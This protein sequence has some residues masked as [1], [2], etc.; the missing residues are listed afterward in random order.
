MHPAQ[1]AVLLAAHSWNHEPFRRLI[2][3]VDIAA[4]TEELDPVG[5]QEL[6]ERWALGRVWRSTTRAIEAFRNEESPRPW[7]DRLVGHHLWTVRERTVIERRLTRWAGGFWAPTPSQVI[8]SIVLTI[9]KDVRPAPGHPWS[10]RLSRIPGVLRQSFRPAS[11]R[12]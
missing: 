6:A 11:E 3:L 12:L 10:G 9:S 2:D 4:M 8:R 7:A 5:L 1:Q